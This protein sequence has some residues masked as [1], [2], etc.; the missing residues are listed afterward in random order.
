MMARGDDTYPIVCELHP[1]NHENAT[2]ACLPVI[3][4]NKRTL[5]SG[6]FALS[7]A[8]HSEA[9]AIRLVKWGRI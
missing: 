9:N 3:V 8:C 7:D 1:W 2:V 5:A 4:A 6:A